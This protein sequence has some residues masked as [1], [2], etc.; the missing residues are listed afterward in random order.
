M[1]KD[2]VTFAVAFLSANAADLDAEGWFEDKPFTIG[3]VYALADE[4]VDHHLDKED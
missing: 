4:L 1:S 2:V 3:D